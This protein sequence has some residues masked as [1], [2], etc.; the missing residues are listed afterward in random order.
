MSNVIPFPEHRIKRRSPERVS[1]ESVQRLIRRVQEE[2]KQECER[3]E[4]MIDRL[5]RDILNPNGRK[6]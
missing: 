5:W 3:T 1:Q 6:R 4:R 2:K